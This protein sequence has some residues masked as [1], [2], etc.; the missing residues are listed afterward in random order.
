MFLGHKAKNIYYLALYKGWPVL[1]TPRSNYPLD[2]LSLAAQAHIFG[3]VNS[4]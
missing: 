1:Q 4:N 2:I 3:S